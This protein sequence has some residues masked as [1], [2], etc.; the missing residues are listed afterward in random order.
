MYQQQEDEPRQA[1]HADDQSVPQVHAQSHPREARRQIHRPQSQK[2]Q[3]GVH[4]Q[5]HRYFQRRAE[6]PQQGNEEKSR[7]KT[8]DNPL[9]QVQTASSRKAGA[10]QASSAGLRAL[11][12]RI[13]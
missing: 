3:K 9:A 10:A 13:R 8:G 5:L 11:M 12:A 1:Q 4:Q 2:A 7:Q 6:H